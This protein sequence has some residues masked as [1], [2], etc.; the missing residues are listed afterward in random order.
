MNA[1]TEHL[2]G[3]KEH[4][5]VEYR[6]KHKNGNYLWYRDKGGIVSRNENGKPKLL[7]GI[8]INITNEK[9]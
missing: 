8:V 4:Y 5:F 6:I 9:I 2:Q 3:K 1:M 7:V